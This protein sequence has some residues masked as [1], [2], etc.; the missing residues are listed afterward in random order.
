MKKTIYFE[1]LI[2]AIMIIGCTNS[3][4]A[5]IENPYV[6]AWLVT[7]TKYIYPDTIYET[8]NSVNPNVKLLTSKHYAFGR[9]SG[10]N[11]I[12]GGGGE[13]KFKDDVFKTY[14]KYH[15]NSVLVGDSL[16]MKS[17]IEGDLWTITY[18]VDLDTLK[19]EATEIW[20]RIPE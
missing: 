2:I 4:K 9:Q 19:V 17:K 7:Y 10:K 5:A 15:S 16:I 13:Y 14:P 6:G 11:L 8:K 18:S 1:L 12:I 20:K 3:K